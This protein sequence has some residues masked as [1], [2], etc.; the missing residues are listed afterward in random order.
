MTSGFRGNPTVHS[1]SSISL[2]YIFMYYHCLSLHFYTV[3]KHHRFLLFCRCFTSRRCGNSIPGISTDFTPTAM[4]IQ[5]KPVCEYY[6]IG[7]IKT[8]FEYLIPNLI[9]MSQ[10]HWLCMSSIKSSVICNYF[11]LVVSRHENLTARLWCCFGSRDQVKPEAAR[12]ARNWIAF[13]NFSFP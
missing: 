13:N 3:I 7:Y 4:H 5:R 6:T 1:I 10:S 8:S 12:I 2:I 11:W 9:S